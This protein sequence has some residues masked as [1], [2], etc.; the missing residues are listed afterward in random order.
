MQLSRRVFLKRS[1]FAGVNILALMYGAQCWA[2]WRSDQITH[3]ETDIIIQRMLEGATA[4]VSPN[5]VLRTPAIQHN[6]SVVPVS[7]ETSIEKVRA[8][9]ILVDAPTTPLAASFSFPNVPV[10]R[11][12]TRI[13]LDQSTRVWALVEADKQFYISGNAVELQA[14]ELSRVR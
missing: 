8:I 1:S 5:I 7:V 6:P 3:A 14:L 12:S 9:S 13:Q 4:D 2:K 11:V 10:S